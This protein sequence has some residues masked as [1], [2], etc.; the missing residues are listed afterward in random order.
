LAACGGGGGGDTTTSG[1]SPGQLVENP[2]TGLYVMIEPNHGGDGTGLDFSEDPV[3]GRL[4]D[5]VATDPTT[6]LPRTYLRDYLVGEDIVSGPQFSLERN[7][8][9]GR[10]VLTIPQLF[11][12]PAF[13]SAFAQLDDGLQRVLDKG[14][15]ANE[16]PPFTSIPRNA[17]V[18]LRFDDLI[19]GQTVSDATVLIEV[20]YPPTTPFQARIFPDPNH[21]DFR[22]NTFHSTRVLIDMSVSQAEAQA[23]GGIPNPIG[24][25]EAIEPDVPNVVLRIPTILNASAT[26]FELLTNLSGHGVSF[27]GNGST[28]ATSPTLDVVR[29]FRSGGRQVNTNDPFNGFLRD[30]DGPSVMAALGVTVT[31]VA[32]VGNQFDVDLIFESIGC[33]LAP[34]AGDLLVMAGGVTAEVLVDGNPPGGFG[35]V[36]N[37]RCAL[38]AGNPLQFVPGF[39]Q[40]RTPWDPGVPI[41]PECFVRFSPEPLAVPASG[42][43][44]DAS[45][46]IGFDEP[47]FPDSLN[48]FDGIALQKGVGGASVFRN[49][50]LG[51]ITSASDLQEFTLDPMV[52]LDHIQGSQES[53]SIELLA[54]VTDLAGNALETPLPRTSFSIANGSPTI[55]SGAFAFTFSEGAT[56]GVSSA[57]V[58]DS[59]DGKPE[60]RGQFIFDPERGE[61]RPRSVDRFSGTVDLD[62]CSVAAMFTPGTTVMTSGGGL[63]TVEIGTLPP[64]S[65]HGSRTMTT[66]RYFDMGLSLLDESTF[67]IDVEGLAWAPFTQGLAL[68]FFTE[69][70]IGLAHSLY[71]PDNS[72][73]PTSL[74]PS[75]PASGL[76]TVFDANLLDP[77]N[78]PIEVVHERALGYLVQ[79][80]D[81]FTVASGQRMAPWPLNRNQ[82]PSNYHFYTYRDT[83]L[84]AEGGLQS[85]GA[86]PNLLGLNNTANPCPESVVHQFGIPPVGAPDW[87]NGAVHYNGETAGNV[88]SIG[89]P[90]LIDF[91]AY[92]TGS[93]QGI[94]QLRYRLGTGLGVPTMRI[95][96][97]GAQLPNGTIV[98]V[99][100]DQEISATGSFDVAGVATPGF[101]DGFYLGQADFVVRVNRVH[102]IWLDAAAPST[103]EPALFLP[104]ALDQPAGTQ[105]S[106]AYRGAIVLTA[107]A[108]VDPEMANLYDPYGNIPSAFAGGSL[109]V[110]FLNND[111]G[112]K[113]DI[114]ELDGARYLQM[115]ITMV[116]NV[117]KDIEP[118]LTAL[119]VSFSN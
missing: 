109:G 72:I 60:F 28:L 79:P 81:Q 64:L 57:N 96:S 103:W 52:E 95:H 99:N 17:A 5:I 44:T 107:N 91:R 42:V 36:S 86:D 9:T 56:T 11:G 22:G 110:L 68:D 19:D 55:N 87:I 8:A 16:L 53:Y 32:P 13:Q 94:N 12:T 102:S 35:Q 73:D 74:L 14:L 108:P 62:R 3:W 101:D 82:A 46:Q 41:V 90:L 21:G 45:I 75:H 80:L 31:L 106:V 100:P 30:T 33:A 84:E 47:M 66:W 69:F 26:Q 85:S 2:A 38:I 65:A 89:L 114:N 4:V 119:G 77:V 76:K 43:A 6:L 71:L 7:A 118:Y 92:P 70:Q 112:W 10:E 40:Y 27:G 50:V 88:P 116:S 23:V 98:Q 117:E 48:S 61:L 24:L 25:P 83:S 97:T 20:G 39:G 104:G 58:D 37:V 105:V 49:N 51:V 78:D 15:G 54:G 59:G 93:P 115:R 113:D 34:R 29:A 63:T 1:G 18:A 67:N 111:S